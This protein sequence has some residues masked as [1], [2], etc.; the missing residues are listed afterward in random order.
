MLQS[1]GV[2]V[3]QA[4]RYAPDGFKTSL[5]TNYS[6]ASAAENSRS[7]PDLNIYTS[8][9]AGFVV[10]ASLG[11]QISEFKA[12]LAL[13]TSTAVIPTRKTSPL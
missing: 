10:P 12:I 4:D 9:W 7:Q 1:K 13:F 5:S 8:S 2:S 6:I 3:A 11:T